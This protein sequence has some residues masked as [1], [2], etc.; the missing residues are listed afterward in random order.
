MIIRNDKISKLSFH[1]I[2]KKYIDKVK[3]QIIKI[4][5]QK[6]KAIAELIFFFS[7]CSSHFISLVFESNNIERSKKKELKAMSQQT[8]NYGQAMNM[9]Q[10]GMNMPQPF[11]QLSNGNTQ[12][13]LFPNGY[14][15]INGGNESI[16]VES[17]SAQNTSKY[18]KSVNGMGMNGNVVLTN[19]NA[20]AMHPHQMSRH[21]VS[22]NNGNINTN[23]NTN[24]NAS[25]N[26]NSS[27]N[28]TNTNTNNNNN[29]NNS[30]NLTNRVKS[31][32]AEEM[33]NLNEWYPIEQRLHVKDIPMPE[34]CDENDLLLFEKIPP[35]IREGE[36]TESQVFVYVH[37]TD[38]KL[39]YILGTMSTHTKKKREE[40]SCFPPRNSF[41]RMLIHQ[42]AGELNLRHNVDKAPNERESFLNAIKISRVPTSSRTTFSCLA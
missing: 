34:G 6:R 21:S 4:F 28:I 16:S 37:F 3:I 24:I 17:S 39:T 8:P 14:Q 33:R 18:S 30:N 11:L 13:V 7:Y 40:W 1:F 41:E 29:N 5:R 10:F 35:G 26:I 36:R 20:N 32:S 23:T 38:C 19:F 27:N 9:Q 2:I 12:S 15:G 25:V 42:I 22:N 31:L